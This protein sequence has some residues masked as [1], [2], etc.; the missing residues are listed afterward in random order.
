V[1]YLCTG[2]SARSQIAQALV[3]HLSEHT[4]EAVSAGSSPR[5]LHPNAVRVMRERGIDISGRRPKHLH[6]LSRQRFD[7]IISL[8]DRVGEVCPEFPGKPETIHWSIPDPAAEPGSDAETYAAFE[9]TAADLE[10][11]IRFFLRRINEPS[12][13]HGGS[14]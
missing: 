6:T 1:F 13:E 8:C 4:I 10:S 12:F 2:N 7:Y 5:R 3:E 11:R 14:V 9:L